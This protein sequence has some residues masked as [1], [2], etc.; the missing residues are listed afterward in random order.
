MKNNEINELYIIGCTAFTSEEKIRA[1]MESGMN[2]VLSK[3][4]NRAR[5]S[6]V[7][8]NYILI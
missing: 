4:L 7:V 5:L 2:T 8:K 6:E 3:P 1:C